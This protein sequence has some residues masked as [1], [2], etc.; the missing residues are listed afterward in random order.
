[1]LNTFIIVKICFFNPIICFIDM[2][3]DQS[4]ILSVNKSTPSNA[5]YGKSIVEGEFIHNAIT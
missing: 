3:N 1:M 2:P 4:N 5:C